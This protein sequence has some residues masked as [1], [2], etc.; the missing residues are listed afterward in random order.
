MAK[1]RKKQ[2]NR[3]FWEKYGKQFER[4]ERHLKEVIASLDAKIAEERSARGENAA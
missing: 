3:E 4:T 2:T 1:K